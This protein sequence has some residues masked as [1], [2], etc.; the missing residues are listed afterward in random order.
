MAE[1]LSG[2]VVVGGS[3]GGSP[4]G[5]GADAPGGSFNGPLIPH[6]AIASTAAQAMIAAMDRRN[7][8]NTVYDIITQ[9]RRSLARRGRRFR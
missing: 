4:V 8:R 6:P 7:I 2:I 9:V 5:A 3:P 1:G